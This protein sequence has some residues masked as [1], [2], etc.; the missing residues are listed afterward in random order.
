[1]KFLRSQPTY[2]SRI[3]QQLPP[4]ITASFTSEQLQA[5]KQAFGNDQ[6]QQHP[7]DIRTTIS[8][9]GLKFYLVILAGREKRSR[10]RLRQEREWHPVWKPG[11]I[12]VLFGFCSVPIVIMWVILAL[13]KSPIRA[14]S[15]PHPTS[16][17]WLTTQEECEKTGRTWSQ[18]ESKCWD[19][20]HHPW[21]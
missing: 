4:E 8:L 18:L 6:W 9:V 13:L 5:I 1:M 15:H 16:I 2:N 21:F 11:N 19:S 3:L 10:D 17:P 14:V 12:A 20:E 7:V